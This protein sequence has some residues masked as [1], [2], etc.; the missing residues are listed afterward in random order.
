MPIMGS[1]CL[2]MTLTAK[3]GGATLR[4][5]HQHFCRSLSHWDTVRITPKSAQ[6]F[7]GLE[8][9]WRR[10]CSSMLKRKSFTKYGFDERD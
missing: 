6:T 1:W 4:P 9:S 10:Y 7:H 5:R 8:R 2:I 3:R